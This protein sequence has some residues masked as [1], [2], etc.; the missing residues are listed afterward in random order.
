MIYLADT[1][2]VLFF[3]ESDDRISA[4]AKE[5]ILDKNNDIFV[6]IASIWEIAIKSSIGRLLLQKSL[7][8]VIYDIY[9]NNFL[10]LDIKISHILENASLFFHHKDPFDRL[11][12]AQSIVENIPVISKNKV[13]ELYPVKKIW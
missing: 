6:S 11:I 12:I 7:K 1:H 8:E 10:T 2:A 13:F 9:S 3:N 5:I 4:L